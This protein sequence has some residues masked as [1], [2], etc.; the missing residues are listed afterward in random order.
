MYVTKTITA[1]NQWTK[2]IELIGDFNYSAQGTFVAKVTLQRSF[3]A[4][5]ED[6]DFDIDPV[7]AK[8]FEPYSPFKVSGAH[9]NYRY[10]VKTGDFTSGTINVRLG[11]R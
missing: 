10:G 8:G 4:T 5:W 7:S 3:G 11:V 9:I 6:V 1:E 2:S